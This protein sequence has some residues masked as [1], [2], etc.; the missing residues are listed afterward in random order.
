M[1]NAKQIL[2][3]WIMFNDEPI[4]IHEINDDVCEIYDQYGED[5]TLD[6]S[7]LDNDAE[8]IIVKRP[9][10][11]VDD[12]VFSTEFQEIL[13]IAEVDTNDYYIPYKLSNNEWST[14]FDLQVIKSSYHLS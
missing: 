9:E 7:E 8:L 1:E 11:A 13:M 10:F 6:M 12:V 14:P 2:H 4:Y 5:W 3:K